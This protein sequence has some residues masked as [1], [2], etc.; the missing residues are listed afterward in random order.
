MEEAVV[1]PYVLAAMF[2]LVAVAYASVGL[3]GGSSYTALQSI[4][5]V[6]HTA[7]PTISLAMNVVVTSVGT[8]N[9]VRGRH[10]RR[11]LVLPFLVT[12]IPMAFLGGSLG[13]SK[14]VFQWALL[15]SL[16]V[17]ALRIYLWR[18][19][20]LGIRLSPAARIVF[21]LVAG[22][23]LG[24]VAGIVGNGGGIFLVPLIVIFRLGTEKE[25]AACGSV[26]IF[27]NSL[28]GL[29]ARLLTHPIDIVE[30]LPLAGAVLV[31][32][33]VGSHLG[34][35]RLAPRTMQRILGAIV[36]VAVGLLARQ[37]V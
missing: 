31:G 34:S 14:E 11:G 21:S 32:G 9:Y 22:S 30:I 29:A 19:T 37:L 17:V 28:A 8:L 13:I 26:F 18:D 10:L 1:S 12:S 6:S 4:F 27:V 16:V 5:G 7:I 3:G 36:L 20:P 24:L 2:L 15:A 25:A 35:A 23:I 33:A